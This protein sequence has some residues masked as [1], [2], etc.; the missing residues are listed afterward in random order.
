MRHSKSIAFWGLVALF[1]VGFLFSLA[2]EMGSEPKTPGVLLSA[3]PLVG[4]FAF[5]NIREMRN[6]RILNAGNALSMEGRFSEALRVFDT[7]G[8][9]W[10]PIAALPLFRGFSLLGL[11]RLEELRRTYEP[12]VSSPGRSQRPLLPFAR[13]RLALVCALL[14][15]VARARDLAGQQSADPISLLASAILAIRENKHGEACALLE[16]NETYQLHGGPR[17]LRDALHAWSVRELTGESQSIDHVA[18][19]GDGDRDEL[20]GAWPEFIE[21]LHRLPAI[22]PIGGLTDRAAEPVAPSSSSLL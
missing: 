14:G 19:W 18:L 8:N 20:A 22:E 6:L 15:G 7:L 13:P 9:A 21:V 5:A 11:W 10:P 12:L 3:L 4:M 2:R 17:G 1:G 16:R